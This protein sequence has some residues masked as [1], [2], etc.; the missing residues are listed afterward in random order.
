MCGSLHPISSFDGFHAGILQCLG[1]VIHDYLSQCKH[2]YQVTISVDI[3]KILH[4]TPEF[5]FGLATQ[6]LFYKYRH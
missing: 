1:H 3:S 5:V 6:A 4:L 2:G